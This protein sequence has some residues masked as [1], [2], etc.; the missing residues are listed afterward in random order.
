MNKIKISAKPKYYLSRLPQL[1]IPNGFYR[2][3]LPKL[4]GRISDAD[5]QAYK[6]RVDYYCKGSSSFSITEN[7]LSIDQL[8]VRKNSAYFLDLQELMRY[9]P[10]KLKFY[11][12]F[13]DVIRIPAKPSLLKS[14]PI[15]DENQHSVLLKLNKVRHFS[16]PVQDQL[17]FDQKKN[18]VVWRGHA[19]PNHHSKR[20]DLVLQ[21]CD[22]PTFDIGQSNDHP[23]KSSA[24]KAFLSIEDQLEYKFILS[25]E[26]NDVATNLKWIMASS[27][28]CIMKKP[29]FET[30]FME[31]KL[32][33]GV[34]YALI[35]D[36]FSDL[37][38]VVNYYLENPEKAQAI[39]HNANRWFKQFT[40]ENSERLISLMVLE[41]YFK[42]SGQIKY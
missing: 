24:K 10:A 16:I 30:W 37:E 14:R 27:S 21:Y 41:K 33:P 13:G 29:R 36:D 19:K 40:N 7:A 38:E 5:Y 22:H 4:L 26:G 20:E 35:K 23:R 11:R 1:L 34:H 25:V 9:F 28:L 15:N 42:L 2:Q 39:I 31:G 18:S 32:E 12:E 6:E 3:Q 8:S 17:N